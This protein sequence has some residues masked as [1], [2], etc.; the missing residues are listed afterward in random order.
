MKS[1]VLVLSLA[2]APAALVLA[3]CNAT[4]STAIPGRTLASFERYLTRSLTPTKA[5]LH[6]GPPDEE[7]G[8]GLR[9]FK[10]RLT[11]GGKIWLAFPG[12]A[13]ITYA[14]LEA[15]DGTMTDLPL[16]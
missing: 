6:F 5:R 1:L 15:R 16:D 3:A 2:T 12:D 13:P 4:S 10:Y 9:I 11:D 14:K 7:T 8:S